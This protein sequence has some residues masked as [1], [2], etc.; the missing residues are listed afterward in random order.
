MISTLIL[1]LSIATVQ[2]TLEV[3]IQSTGAYRILVNGKTWLQS[4]RSE[5]FE[6]GMWSSPA[7]V[8]SL[9]T[10]GS[11]ALGGFK[12]TVLTYKAPTYSADAII[13]QYDHGRLVS[14]TTNFTT[15]MK[16]SNSSTSADTTSSR[17]PV[18]KLQKP[19]A[20]SLGCMAWGGT[21]M[22]NG[23]AGPAIGSWP[24]T[25]STGKDGGPHAVFDLDTSDTIVLSHASQFMTQSFESINGNLASGVMGGVTEIPAGF[26]VSTM[27]SYSSSGVN[28]AMSEWGA[29][30]LKMYGKTTAHRDADPILKVLGYNTDHGAYYY[31]HPAPNMTM[32]ATML[33]VQSKAQQQDIP[34]KYILLDSWWYFKGPQDGVTN[35]T[36]T[37]D[38]FP[39]GGDNA[40]KTFTEQTKWMVIGHNRYWDHGTSYS[41][42]NGGP[43]NF[44]D[45]GAN[46]YV[47][48]LTQDFWDFLMERSKAWGL[49]TYEQ[50]WL[51]NEFNSVPYL[52]RSATMARDWLLQMGSAAE[53]N[54]LTIQYCMPYTRHVLQSVEVPVVTQV[55]AS[56]DY[57]P[58]GNHAPANWNL[59]GSSILA[60]AVALA[61]YKDNFWS[62]TQEPGGSCGSTTN[63]D[64]WRAAAVATLSTGPVTPGDGMQYMN[65]SMIMR[66]CSA[67]GTLLKPAR[68]I[69]FLD[70]YIY[71]RGGG[72]GPEGHVWSTYSTIGTARYDIIFSMV[73]ADYKLKPSELTLDRVAGVPGKA[74]CY[75]R[76]TKSFTGLVVMPLDPASGTIPLKPPQTSNDFDLSYVAPVNA[77]G[78]ALLGELSKWVPVS[79]Q[80]VTSVNPKN[81]DLEVVVNGAPHEEVV[82]TFYKTQPVEVR[83]VLPATGTAI[84]A[85]SGT[86]H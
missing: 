37:P 31:Y 82:L 59:G 78:W 27:I 81:G 2:G 14:F 33:A 45:D 3:E 62:S 18:F 23:N 16:Q 19:A 12:Q 17:F 7:P 83:C 35:W 11:D 56:D 72:N 61:P 66:S 54:G 51:Y 76:D 9:P 60:H 71:K 67:D 39:P 42:H 53:K 69:T 44:S 85:S 32:G 20:L 36:A 65:K 1:L 13:K 74:V 5:F 55:R 22:N 73:T 68:P 77:N 10:A 4:E 86:C 40:L 30:L 84:V 38:T 46:H 47:V 21:F 50:D 34:F 64:V 15:G 70:S 49:T 63:P 26:S 43:F 41:I 80:R 25:T 79:A 75:S 57:V 28:N 29:T 52:Q 24:E 6:G 58:G 48:P 8:V